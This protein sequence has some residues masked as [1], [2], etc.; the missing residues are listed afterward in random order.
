VPIETTCP[1][2][3]EAHVVDGFTKK[4]VEAAVTSRIK[5]KNAE[6]DLLNKRISDLEAV[7]VSAIT[8]ERDDAV[9]EL[10]TIREASEVDAAFS[11]VGIAADEA[12]RGAF[13]TIYESA[14]TGAE[15]R[16]SFAA[17]VQSD[18]ARNHV[19]LRSHYAPPAGDGRAAAPGVPPVKPP[20]AAPP[21][22]NVAAAD[23]RTKA[24]TPAEVAAYFRSPEYRALP[25]D[26]RAAKRAELEAQIAKPGAAAV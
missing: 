19:L 17:W 10:A 15:D 5:S 6:I 18:D 2:C 9:R 23:T 4:D 21:E 25:K 12:L 24:P 7:D 13:R 20:K 1:H 16:P 26:D 22:G 11:G 14:T 3:S 8:R